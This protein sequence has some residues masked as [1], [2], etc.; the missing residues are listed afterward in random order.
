LCFRVVHSESICSVP[1][2]DDVTTARPSTPQIIAW[3]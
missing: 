1:Q 2:P 3:L